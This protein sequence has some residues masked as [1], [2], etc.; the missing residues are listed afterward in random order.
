MEDGSC[1]EA[2]RGQG[3]EGLWQVEVR[4]QCG[5]ETVA[6]GDVG[7][8]GDEELI[9]LCPLFRLGVSGL[10]SGRLCFYQA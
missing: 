7:R 4:R 2:L 8:G 3:K 5:Q 10:V 6:I 9:R 1:G